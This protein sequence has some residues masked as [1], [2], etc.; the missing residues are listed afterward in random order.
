MRWVAMLSVC[1]AHRCASRDEAA[2]APDEARVA[3][4]NA[5]ANGDRDQV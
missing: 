5:A 4:S 2:I 3:A 1:V